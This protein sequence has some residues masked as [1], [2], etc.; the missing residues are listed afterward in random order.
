MYVLTGTP[1]VL[2]TR[3]YCIFTLDVSADYLPSRED[4][5]QELPDLIK[6]TTRRHKRN[7]TRLRTPSKPPRA[8]V[9]TRSQ[10]TSTNEPVC[11]VNKNA[12]RDSSSSFDSLKG[13]P[14]ILPWR[15]AVTLI[16]VSPVEKISKA[17]SVA[18]ME[19]QS[20]ET[21][22]LPSVASSVK[23]FEN[24]CKFTRSSEKKSE[25]KFRKILKRNSL[26]S[27]KSDETQVCL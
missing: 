19:T 24:L 16:E 2:L 25:N 14:G 26:K 10:Q 27:N 1:G 15:S 20:I 9:N 21:E 23:L 11:F 13:S 8:R 3:L 5:R 4:R 12:S 18:N 17:K 22:K 7:T 6:H